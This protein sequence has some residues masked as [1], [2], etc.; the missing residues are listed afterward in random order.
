MFN[1]NNLIDNKFQLIKEIGSG[2][3]GVVYL[4]YHTSLQKY[5]VLKKL[6]NGVLDSTMFRREA[7]LLKNL[8]H[9]YLPTVYDFIAVGNDVYTVIDYI[10]G[11]SL[12]DIIN[13]GTVIDLNTARKW[14]TQLAEVVCYL[15]KQTPQ[16]IHSD[17]KPANILVTPANDICLIDFNISLDGTADVSGYS[18]YYASPEQRYCAQCLGSGMIPNMSVDARTDIFSM[19][20]TFY[21]VISGLLPLEDVQNTPLTDLMQS[22]DVFLS[23]VDRCMAYS[24]DDRY[25]SAEQVLK[26]LNNIFKLTSTYKL[27]NLVRWIAVTLGTAAICAGVI[28]CVYGNQL[29]HNDRFKA[30]YDSVFRA[31]NESKYDEAIVQGTKLLNSSSSEDY[32]SSNKSLK[33]DMLHLIGSSY[34]EQEEYAQAAQ[35]DKKAFDES[36]YTNSDC[37]CE[38][39][40]A[41]IR[42]GDTLNAQKAFEDAERYNLHAFQID[43]IKMEFLISENKYEEMLAFYSEKKDDKLYSENDQ[44]LSLCAVAST[45]LNRYSDALSFSSSAYNLNGS[46]RNLRRLGE[47]YVDIANE[48][49]RNGNASEAAKYCQSAADCFRQL[50]SKKFALSSDYIYLLECCRQLDLRDEAASLINT[51]TESFSSDYIVFAEIARYYSKVSQ[52]ALAASYAQKAV[53][54]MPDTAE[55]DSGRYYKYKELINSLLR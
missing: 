34:F 38:Y 37:Y 54:L 10:E 1:D 46:Y 31:F 39:L 5:V 11:Q 29:K 55:D 40:T 45:N 44:V 12:E 41:L 43:V 42:S 3:T 25:Q 7:D 13:S 4:A 24:P 36:G 20:A 19:G 32:F 21:F 50:T 2:G 14:F 16:I 15:H 6:K 33:A 17:I 23:I 8:H 52:S 48:N 27:L 53:A 30:E 18:S 9:T 47:T 49:I 22:S 28:M 26:Q 51:M 35:Y